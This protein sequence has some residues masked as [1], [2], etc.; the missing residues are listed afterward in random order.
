MMG[1]DD[2]RTLQRHEKGRREW[3]R[4]MAAKGG[5]RAEDADA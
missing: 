2:I 5:E 4:G 1:M 3:M